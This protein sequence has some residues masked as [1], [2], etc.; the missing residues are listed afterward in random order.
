MS[1]PTI[2]ARRNLRRA[3][4]N[5]SVYWFLGIFVCLLTPEVGFWGDVVRI[6]VNKIANHIG[7]VRTAKQLSPNSLGLQATY[8]FFSMTYV[9]LLTWLAF[10]TQLRTTLGK[11]EWM[12][13]KAS[14]KSWQLLVAYF[15]GIGFQLIWAF[16]VLTWHSQDPPSY[17][18]NS[19]FKRHVWSSFQGGFIFS[20]FMIFGWMIFTVL[21]Y[22]ARTMFRQNSSSR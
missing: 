14:L 9:P 4:L 20:N 1:T 19:L 16:L 17:L 2:Q 7:I 15:G 6:V 3:L 10:T 12:Q 22:E 8:V 5:V 21:M 18:D 13:H 11:N